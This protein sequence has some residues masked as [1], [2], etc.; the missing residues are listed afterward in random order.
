MLPSLGGVPC[1][2]MATRKTRPPAQ[3]A[4]IAKSAIPTRPTQG[5]QAGSPS[6]TVCRINMRIGVKTGKSES[7]VANVLSGSFTT[8]TITNIGIITGN[9]AGNI[10]D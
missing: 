8:G 7:S 10:S 3:T 6:T 9:I 4:R 1:I 5:C 2:K